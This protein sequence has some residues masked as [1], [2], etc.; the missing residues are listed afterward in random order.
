MDTLHI[1]IHQTCSKT[2]D[3]N[4]D[5]HP[6]LCVIHMTVN[7]LGVSLVLAMSDLL[8]KSSLDSISIWLFDLTIFCSLYVLYYGSISSLSFSEIRHKITSNTSRNWR[9]LKHSAILSCWHHFCMLRLSKYGYLDDSA[10]KLLTCLMIPH[11]N[12]GE[13]SRKFSIWFNCDFIGLMQTI[14]IWAW[15]KRWHP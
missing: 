11:T 6:N 7:A 2:N 1:F 10:H 8:N 5:T 4:G 3:F 15:W 13:W 12:F 9:K 14:S